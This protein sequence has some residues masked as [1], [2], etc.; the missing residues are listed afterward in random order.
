MQ[1][2]TEAMTTNV[3]E[4]ADRVYR[5]TT[6]VADFDLQFHQF[7]VADE[8]PLLYHTGMRG[9][10][11]AVHQAVRRVL[12]PTTIRWIGFSHFEADECGALNEWLAA[13]P[14]AQPLS[15]IVGTLVNLA[16]FAVRPGRGLADGERFTT[17]ASRFRF[18]HTPHL[19][20]GWD[21]GML[22]E[23]TR[24]VLFCS[25]LLAHGGN[26]ATAVSSGD[27]LTPHREALLRDQAGPF[28]DS[29]A[30][31]SGTRRHLLRL[32]ELRPRLLATMH[33]SS[34]AG[35][36]ARVL[37]DLDGTLAEV[38]GPVPGAAAAASG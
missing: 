8:E 36:G 4:I 21:A 15:S 2:T 37:R 10:F 25:D 26:P 18:L 13:A 5:I 17:G 14:M 16:D 20:H 12:D 35:D 9:M 22:W 38:F 29:V 28:L 3:A 31:T 30:Y 34:Y 27:L 32:A 24:G 6:H 11:A 1:N 7:L 33:G 23:E 19:P